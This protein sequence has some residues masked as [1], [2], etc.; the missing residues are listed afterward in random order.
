MADVG[1]SFFCFTTFILSIECI[2]RLK[3]PL[4]LRRNSLFFFVKFLFESFIC[5]K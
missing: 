2:V 3:I 5:D 1:P 4:K